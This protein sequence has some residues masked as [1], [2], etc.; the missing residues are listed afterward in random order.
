MKKI[1][2]KVLYKMYIIKN[3]FIRTAIRKVISYIDGG[4][5]YSYY[6]RRILKEYHNIEIGNGSYG[7]CFDP[8]KT[9]PNV[10]V[11]KYVSV[12]S[13]V[14]FY[15]RNHAYWKVSSHPIFYN[16]L[17]GNVKED[18][19]L[20]SQLEIGN[21]VWI[22]QNVVVLPS[23]N[24]IGDGVVIGAGAI[25]TKDVPDYA[26]VTGV[27]AQVVK[28]RFS[29]QQI[30]ELKQ[31]KWWNWDDKKI[32]ENSEYFEDIDSF[33]KKFGEKINEKNSI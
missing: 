2:T 16:K 19:V 11:G 1:I 29:E 15:T 22:G 33:I 8:V 31:I 30:N 5:Y 24:K 28:Y 26:I 3:R 9:S 10:K 6:L 18:T 7:S 21:D 17:L 12:A 13:N 14:H 4:Q 32:R 25:V 23:C 27:P 20:N